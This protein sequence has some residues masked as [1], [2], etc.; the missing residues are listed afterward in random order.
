MKVTRVEI[1][2]PFKGPKELLAYVTIE[3][4]RCF[5]VHG[6]RLI[7]K[8]SGRNG[9]FIAMPSKK[10]GDRCSICRAYNAFDAKFCEQC[11]APCQN[12]PMP[13]E[14]LG[15]RRHQDVAHPLTTE[16]RRELEVAV[17]AAYDRAIAEANNPTE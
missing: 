10:T 13:L 15:V 8:T 11:G 3:L 4:D 17:F 6:M 12:R 5:V 1:A 7:N 16:F 14:E 2:I 9:Q